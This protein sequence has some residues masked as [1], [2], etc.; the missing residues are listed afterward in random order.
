[1]RLFPRRKAA[2]VVTAI[3]AMVLGLG[4]TGAQAAVPDQGLV[5]Q[6]DFTQ[7]SGA[8]VPNSAPGSSLGAATV[9]NLQATDWTGSQLTLRGGAKTSTGNWVRLPNDILQGKTS[10][11]VVAEVKA[12][13]AMLNGFHFLWNIGNDS[14]ATEYFFASLNCGSGRAP[15]VG[16]KSAGVERL[17]QSSSCGV[18][19]NQWVSVVAVVDGASG[20]ASLYIDGKRA[21]Q[22]AMPV[23]P[24]NVVDQSLNAIGRAPWPDPLFQG[25][26]SAFRVYDRA[27]SAAE[28][29]QVSD[30]DAQTHAAELQAQAQ[31]I[32]TSLNVSDVQTST[33]IDLPTSSGRVTWTSSNPAVVATDGT[34]TAPLAGQP[35]IPVQLTATAAVRGVTATKTITVTV[36]PSTESAEQRIQRLA[37]RFVIPSVIESGAALPAA[38]EGT[39]IAVTSATSGVAVTDTISSSSEE[40]LDATITIRVTDSATGATTDRAFTVRVLPAATTT[41]LLAYNRTPTTVNEANN[42]DVALSMHLALEDGAGWSPLNENYGIFFAKTSTTPPASGTTESI[43]R[44]L[45]SPHL[46]HLADGGYGIAATR[47]ARGGASDGTQAS[48]FLFAKSSDLLSYREIGL[49]NVGVTSGV[50]EP[51]VVWD[52]AS[53]R[54]VVSWIS[55]AGAPYY[56]TFAD[57]ADVSTRGAVLRGTVTGSAGN[58][59]TGVANFAS[60]NAVPVAASIADALQ[61]RFGRIANT[62]V[63]ALD[64]VEVEQGGALSAADLPE[65]AELSYDDGS[66]ASRAIAWDAASL[67]AVDTSAPGTY[68]VTGSVKAPQYATPFADERADPSVF[69]FDWNGQQKFLMIATED[70]NLNPID[71]ANGPHM[72][73]RIADTIEELSDDAVDAGRNV[74]IDLLRAGD[75]DADGGVMTGCFWAP[76]FHVIGGKLSILFMPCYNGSNGRPDMWTGRASIIQL[77]QDAQGADL[78]PAVPANWTKAQKVVRSDGSILNPIQSISLDMTY[79]QDSGQ[80]YYM[81]QMLGAIFI[82]KMD[83]ADP[84]RLTSAPVRIL[85]PEYA[86]DNTIA[87]GP[88]VHV[89]DG[90]LYM[91][92]SGSTVGDSYTTG[93]ATATA[94]QNVDLTD[95]AAWSKLNYPI[96]KSG[97]FNGAW[98]LG[99]GHGM[100]SHDEDDNLLYV[101]HA[102]T[103][104]DGLSGRDMFVRRVHWAADGLPVFDM[105]EDEEVAPDNRAVK[106][107]VTVTAAPAATLDYTA[108]V[109][110]RCVAGKVVQTVLITNTDDVAL[111]LQTTSPYGTKATASLAAGKSVS[112]A[113][114]TRLAT[115]PPGSVKVDASATVG[116]TAVTGTQ[117]V[118]YPQANC[119]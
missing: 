89:H 102:R 45:R 67:A 5:A 49:V 94:G 97:V 60:G 4:A 27:L 53:Q 63:E 8:S 19:A 17:V 103:D 74:E 81:W 91:I 66:K 55:D 99:T 64:G 88:N 3:S 16:L 47:T 12:S 28:V 41:Q 58:P 86:W 83:P 43:I 65:R 29:A 18:T 78:D 20:T 68:E 119:G 117:T 110:A 26:I 87:E 108:T 116:G 13:Q 76:E 84:T 112:Y 56:T 107:A 51:A 46:F 15:L 23:T 98:Q 11:T 50:N 38:P 96:Q 21:A 73:I 100:W 72:P 101:F 9:Q 80:S 42:A 79:F 36:L 30:S 70:L 22:G 104:H 52:S 33:D 62:D 85:A 118:T 54:Y 10:A 44:S 40:A 114:T 106:V 113:F 71:P 25:A 95:P 14:S 6:Y 111:A 57:L 109:T 115:M 77:K 69:R 90:K 93:L 59:G 2:L 34:V 48:S 105:E 61:V 31:A 32:L 92:Y 1:M 35:A 39:T 37:Q 24:A 7:T 82:A 75:T